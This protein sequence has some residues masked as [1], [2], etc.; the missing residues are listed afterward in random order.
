MTSSL[1]GFSNFVDQKTQD[2]AKKGGAL[3]NG[4]IGFSAGLS[5]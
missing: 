3:Q 5:T 4:K 1:G 2:F